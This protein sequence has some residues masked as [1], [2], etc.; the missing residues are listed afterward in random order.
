MKNTR[1]GDNSQTN[2]EES[3]ERDA[4]NLSY[5]ILSAFEKHRKRTYCKLAQ[6]VHRIVDAPAEENFY[7]K[8]RRLLEH[9]TRTA[10]SCMQT[11]QGADTEIGPQ[12]GRVASAESQAK[13]RLRSQVT[14]VAVGSERREILK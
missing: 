6:V 7:V 5:T 10:N 13:S 8:R 12:E 1:Q 11:E 4:L 3:V 9:V 2:L 14:E